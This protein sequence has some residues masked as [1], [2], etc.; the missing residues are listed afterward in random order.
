MARTTGDWSKSISCA[1]AS[2]IDA[3]AAMR[4]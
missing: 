4:M 2:V 1:A 3:G